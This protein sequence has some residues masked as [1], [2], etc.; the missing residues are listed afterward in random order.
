M[1]QLSAGFAKAFHSVF[2]DCNSFLQA[3]PRQTSSAL[4]NS[5]QQSIANTAPYLGSY[6]L[7]CCQSIAQGTAK[8]GVA[9]RLPKVQL[10]QKVLSLLRDLCAA[11]MSGI[12]PQ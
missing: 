6:M 8:G 7:R 1:Q 11:C 3:L 4:S 10:L 5:L 12:C 9:A 2:I